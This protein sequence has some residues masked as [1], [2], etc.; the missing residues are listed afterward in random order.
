MAFEVAVEQVLHLPLTSGL[1]V[2]IEV[3]EGLLNEQVAREKG[4]RKTSM[5]SIFETSAT[6]RIGRELLISQPSKTASVITGLRA[7]SL[8]KKACA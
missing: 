4:W 1:I 2:A 5:P 8:A 6:T 7:S 3:R